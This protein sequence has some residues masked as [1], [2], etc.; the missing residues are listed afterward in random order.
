MQ[1][2]KRGLIYVA[3][4]RQPW[5]QTHAM[6]PTPEFL[7][8]ETLRVY[9]SV[10]DQEG[11]GRVSYIDVQA[12]NPGKVLAVASLPI[13]DIGQPGTFDENGVVATSIVTLPDGRKFLYY[14]GFEL[15]TRI[16]Y[17]LL[18][19]LAISED[20]GNSFRRVQKTPVLERSDRELFFRCGPFVL[21]ENGVFRMWYV[22]GDRWLNINGK[23]LP[24]YTVNYLESQDGIHWDKQGK[25]CID[26]QNQNEHGFGRP[27]IV[28]HGEKY[29]MFYSIR[30]KNLGYRLGYAESYDGIDWVRE[31]ELIGM[32][33]SAAGWDAE[34]VCYSAVI[35][36]N[37]RYYMFYNGNRFGKTGCGWAKLVSW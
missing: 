34:T 22:A 7:D 31:D 18:T 14:V 1:W 8:S 3:D 36:V 24:V 21:R 28:K 6:I 33:V 2:S 35:P 9:I 29:K 23:D 10:C 15:G 11:I 5:S 30:V 27:Y 19:G 16:R 12:D 20:G 4:G 32:D 37:D 17:R 13:L 25:V 26:I